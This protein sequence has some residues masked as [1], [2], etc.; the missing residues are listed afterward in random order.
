VG[1]SPEVQFDERDIKILKIMSNNARVSVLEISKKLNMPAKT[2]AYRIKQLEKND[3]IV[4]YKPLLNLEKIGYK[5]YKINIVLSETIKIR[6][7]IEFAKYNP[8]IT[9]IDFTIS[10]NDFEIDI[11]VSTREEINRIMNEIKNI[12]KITDYEEITFREYIKLV[13]F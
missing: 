5:Y 10:Q 13:Y 3:I 2:I 6:E 12:T 1:G 11:E 7:L 8:F 9:Y 4:G